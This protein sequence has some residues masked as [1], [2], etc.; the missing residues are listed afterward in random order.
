MTKSERKPRKVEP[1]EELL[2]IISHFISNIDCSYDMFITV[3][4]ILEE[5]DTAILKNLEI[6]SKNFDK[7]NEDKLMSQ[8]RSF[9]NNLAKFKKADILFRKNTLVGLVI[10]YDEFLGAVLKNIYKT[11]PDKLLTGEKSLNYEELKSLDS[12]ENIIDIFIT[13][14]VE[15][16]LRESH[17]TQIDQI[18]K[19]FKLGIANEFSEYSKFIEL[20]ERRNLFVHASGKVS[21]YYLKKCKE[22]SYKSNSE[23]KIGEQLFVTEN[24]LKECVLCLT[25][26]SIRIGFGLAFRIYPNEIKKIH[27][28]LLDSIGYQ[29]LLNEEW[30]FAERV[31][32]FALSIPDKYKLNDW[33]NKCYIIDFCIALKQLGKKKEFLECLNKYDWTATEPIFKL[34]VAV[35]KDEWKQAEEIM[36]MLNHLT[37]SEEDYRSWPLFKEFRQTREFRKG[38]KENFNKRFVLRLTIEQKKQLEEVK[39]LSKK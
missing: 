19:E 17:T 25:E 24:Y 33:H 6:L 35:L 20:T 12:L 23:L 1:V 26:L 28:H 34:A 11:Y 38:F 32:R 7:K 8:L 16:F 36:K 27:N 39:K 9:T 4:K 29:Y 3:L 10:C 30:V 5:K 13:K 31:F 21:K 2:H 14:D 18:D 22:I 15:N 37:I